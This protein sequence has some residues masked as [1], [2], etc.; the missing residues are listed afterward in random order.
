LLLALAK[1]LKKGLGM[2]SPFCY[3]GGKSRLS[4]CIIKMIPDHTSYCEVFCGAAWVFYRKEPSRYEIINDLDSNLVAF[5]RVLQNHLEE[6]LKQFKWLL[7]SHEW[8]EDYN[9]QMDAGGLTDIQ[10][11][12]RYY[13]VQR[14]CFGGKVKSKTWGAPI[15]HAPRINLVRMEEELSQVHLRLMRVVI[16]NMDYK[17]FIQR[18]DRKK[19]FFYLDP[20]YYKMPFYNHNFDKLKD[21]ETLAKILS[22]LNGKFL[23]SINDEPEIRD[24]FKSFD[25]NSVT[26][27]YSV[28]MKKRAGREPLI[29]NY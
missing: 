16:E 24:I 23:L 10:R 12:A 20:P 21:F 13:Y 1:R 22:N 8:W 26:V 14:Q 3:I 27:D 2:D 6:F 28:N 5:Y 4:N 25:I 9:R 7:S 15:E 18:Y 11:A 17:V 19:T 29:K